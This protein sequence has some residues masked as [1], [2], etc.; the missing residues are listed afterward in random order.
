MG[1]KL[2]DS[3]HEGL[4]SEEQPVKNRYCL[5]CKTGLTD[6]YCPHCG[7]KDIPKRQTL[8]ELLTNF[9][10][11]FWSYE[12]KFFRT[13]QYL[14]LKPGFLA[15]E[16]ND[17]RRESYYHPARMY[18]FISFIYFL[19]FYS[20]PDTLEYEKIQGSSDNIAYKG[21]GTIITIDS[22]RAT[23]LAQYDSVQ[24][25]LPEGK[26]DGWAGRFFAELEIKIAQRYGENRE[27]F[28][29]DFASAFTSNF[30][31]VF[32][33]LLPIFALIL[34]LLYLR[35]DFF[36]S[37]H[38]VFSIYFYN[39]FFLAG[40]FYMLV[41]LSSWLSWMAVLLSVWMGLYLLLGIKNM[42]RER[43]GITIIKCCTFI[44]L[45]SGCVSIGLMLNLMF[46]LMYF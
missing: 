23:T 8:G 1:G 16:Y 3:I 9:V 26:R 14:L 11:S 39:F 25:A 37:E 19:L 30:P 34:K 41:K 7:Q 12:S 45:F 28:T 20:L 2:D 4:P 18:V 40:S 10:S 44:L 6:I 38:L 17:G 27:G 13:A 24:N 31:K 5:N 22:A 42:Y 15:I 35:K 29:K 21:Y 32:F 33:I 46:T 43:W 36:Y